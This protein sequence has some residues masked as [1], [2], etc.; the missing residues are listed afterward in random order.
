MKEMLIEEITQ[1]LEEQLK[2]LLNICESEIEKLFLLKIIKYIATRPFEFQFSFL[3]NPIE[4][5]FKN[6][7]K[8]VKY[9][10]FYKD[11]YGGIDILGL[12][13]DR[14]LQPDESYFNIVPQ[15]EIKMEYKSVKKYRLDF[16]IEKFNYSNIPLKKYCTECDGHEFHS[17]KEQ[18]R[19][20]NIRSQRLL[21]LKNINTIRFSGSQIYNWTDEEIGLFL[22]NL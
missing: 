12:R 22:F 2:C 15:E 8:S 19:L 9:K 21:L 1:S 16:F 6:D 5:T 7:I 3:C 11:A 14:K 20:D 17:S 10:S 18:I 4:I 13:I